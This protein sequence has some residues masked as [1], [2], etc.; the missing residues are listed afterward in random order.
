MKVKIICMGLISTALF[1][2]L[3]ISAF[4]Q[5]DV[6]VTA[7]VPYQ[8][9]ARKAGVE[10]IVKTNR[11]GN[12]FSVLDDIKVNVEIVNNNSER[13]AG[14]A[15]VFVK[16]SFGSIIYIKKHDIILGANS[17]DVIPLT[18]S[19][20]GLPFGPYN[21]DVILDLK[22]NGWVIGNGKFSYY[23]STV[24]SENDWFGINYIGDFDNERIYNDFELFDRLGVSNLRFTMQGWLPQH[25]VTLDEI[26]Y[27]YRLLDK[28]K[29]YGFNLLCNFMPAF[30]TDTRVNSLLAEVEMEESL[31]AALSR[32]AY[33]IKEWEISPSPSEYTLLGNRGIRY[34]EIKKLRD[35]IT[36]YDKKL[37]VIVG[38]DSPHKG[39]LT[40]SFY[41][42]IPQKS[43]YSGFHYSYLKRPENSIVNPTPPVFIMD[44]IK[45]DAGK[46]LK[47]GLN[48]W[49]TDLGFDT[50]A[51][52]LPND[53][54]QAILMS[55]AI[56]QNRASGFDRIYWRNNPYDKKDLPF[57]GNDGVANPSYLAVRNLLIQLDR[58]TESDMLSFNAEDNSLFHVFMFKSGK[59]EKNKKQVLAF[60][61]EDVVMRRQ[62]MIEVDCPQVVL[63]D[64]W[65]N[66]TYLY[67]AN[68]KINLPITEKPSYLDVS[69][70][71]KVHVTVGKQGVL[72]FE[73]RIATINEKMTPAE[74]KLSL[75]VTNDP[76]F[77]RGTQTLM[78]TV[79]CP[80]LFK[81]MLITEVNLVENST[82]QIMLPSFDIADAD[83]VHGKGI[84]EVTARLFVG[85]QCV[86]VAVLPIYY[87]IPANTAANGVE[88]VGNKSSEESDAKRKSSIITPIR[89][90]VV[91]GVIDILRD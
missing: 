21:I 63:T 32:Y 57:I 55:R 30:S 27:S 2:L 35:I 38:V 5:I 6:S 31:A 86:A 13:Y 33:E 59:K 74:T 41:Y 90:G 76:S 70:A 18:Y 44:T 83:R 65:G 89:D 84:T 88:D 49:M 17:T 80:A 51:E 78:V 16:N 26:E 37:K 7:D 42:K 22:E 50:K 45:S 69:D 54:D 8:T 81:E 85:T 64:I 39:N 24:Y 62:I 91:S 34:G 58:T 67:P 19:F 71:K 77:F 36:K 1:L 9:Q 72:S 56:L 79:E 4:S 28:V 23:D 15:E 87:Y 82:R 14:T 25:E 40:E 61:R 68:G 29:P 11:L 48:L 60:W 46:I 75:V 47:H 53:I 12:L 20:G 73:P 66:S 3:S 52:N 43:D 10:I